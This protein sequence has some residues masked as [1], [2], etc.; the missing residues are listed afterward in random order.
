MKKATDHVFKFGSIY[1][2]AL[3]ILVYFFFKILDMGGDLFIKDITA[4]WTDYLIN[5]LLTIF[6]HQTVMT[7]AVDTATSNGLESVEFKKADNLNREIVNDVEANYEDFIDFIGTLNELERKQRQRTFYL[8]VGK[9]H[10]DELTKKEKKKFKKLI[11]QYHDISNFNNHCFIEVTKDGNINYDA[12]YQMDKL[13]LRARLTKVI[14]S[15]LFGIIT[16]NVALK[17]SGVVDAMVSVL[18]MVFALI[19]TYVVTSTPV[20]H[21]LKATIPRKVINK[22][23]LVNTYKQKKGQI[24][25]RL[26][27]YVKMEDEVKPIKKEVEE[28]KEEVKDATHDEAAIQI[29]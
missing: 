16:G 13:R 5:T 28:I 21:K 18:I 7:S 17:A 6:L 29:K 4:N 15:I 3:T 19:I 14:S 24:K 2:T 23:T 12:T 1:I 20:L 9:K 26:E 27:E 25:I 22:M 8:S 10:Y 11:Y